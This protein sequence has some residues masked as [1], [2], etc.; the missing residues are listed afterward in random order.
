V[1]RGWGTKGAG[2][3]ALVP[4]QHPVPRAPHTPRQGRHAGPPP[5]PRPPEQAERLVAAVQAQVHQQAVRQVVGG[6]QLQRL[7]RVARRLVR[8]RAALRLPDGKLLHGKA[9]RAARA[10]L[11]HQRAAAA[12]PA[13]QSPLMLPSLHL[14]VLKNA[15]GSRSVR[16]P[17]LRCATRPQKAQ[18]SCRA[19]K[20]GAAAAAAAPPLTAAAAGP[21]AKRALPPGGRACTCSA[22]MRLP[23]GPCS[24]ASAP[25]FCLAARPVM[26]ASTKAC[27][28]CR[29]CLSASCC[30]LACSTWDS[31]LAL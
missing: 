30:A 17:L 15:R 24:H 8:R 20:R 22:A 28:S 27:S 5:R 29:L 11:P 13:T 16:V 1:G 19:M 21:P 7:Q 6:R 23:C 18:C 31:G 12:K 26:I 10:W 14:A 4:R 9:G 2:A 3:A 25:C